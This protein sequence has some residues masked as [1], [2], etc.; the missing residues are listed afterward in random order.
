MSRVK[1]V[2]KNGATQKLTRQ[3]FAVPKPC[4]TTIKLVLKHHWVVAK[5]DLSFKFTTARLQLKPQKNH[6][7]IP[8]TGHNSP[9][10]QTEK[11]G[12]FPQEAA[13]LI[14]IRLALW[15]SFAFAALALSL[16]EVTRGSLNETPTF[17]HQLGANSPLPWA[18]R[19]HRT[20]QMEA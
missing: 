11:T 3:T 9:P 15:L 12:P 19:S 20:L 8:T 6:V 10:L 7:N 17:H 1:L 13:N 18:H 16:D 4:S 5:W 14:T 2:S